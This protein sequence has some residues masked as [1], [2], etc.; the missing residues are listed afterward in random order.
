[1]KINF[2][3]PLLFIC[4]FSNR[5]A[6]NQDSNSI[7]NDN[8]NNEKEITEENTEALHTA[9]IEVWKADSKT[10]LSIISSIRAYRENSDDSTL[11]AQHKK[12]KLNEELIKINKIYLG[13]PLSLKAVRIKDVTPEKRISDYGIK[14]AKDVIRQLKKDPSSAMIVG[15]GDL[16]NNPLLAWTVG[17][18]LAFC[19][20]CFIETGRYEVECEIPVP[21]EGGYLDYQH[22]IK[23]D[24]TSGE[25]NDQLLDIKI[26]LIVKSEKKAL[27]FSKG[28]IIPVTGKITSIE[29]N[30]S[31][32]SESATIKI[33]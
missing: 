17:L 9:N 31:Q 28:E 20:R 30:G 14:K 32:L 21:D 6:F 5:Y 10:I 23:D 3:I 1:M 27:E 8:D 19:D 18:Q 7:N 15:D 2:I 33:E 26:I 25:E 22:G 4:I 12:Q 13:K 11:Q 24:T 29:Y 16:S